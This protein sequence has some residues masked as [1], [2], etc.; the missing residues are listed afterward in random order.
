MMMFLVRKAEK[1][2]FNYGSNRENELEMHALHHLQAIT[3]QS[4][5]TEG[6]SQL[7]G[8]RENIFHA[9]SAN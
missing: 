9:N 7:L 3:K 8:E 4:H 2:F 1:L 5:F 6:E